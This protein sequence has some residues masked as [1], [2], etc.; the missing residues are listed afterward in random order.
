[1]EKQP[2]KN[3]EKAIAFYRMDYEENPKN[4]FLFNTAF[5]GVYHKKESN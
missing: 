2:G 4:I 3:K 1:M 5:L